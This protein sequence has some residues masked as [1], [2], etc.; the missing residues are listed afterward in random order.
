MNIKKAGVLLDKITAILESIREN[1]IPPNVVEMKRQI[2][3]RERIKAV[4]ARYEEAKAQGKKRIPH[5]RKE[6]EEIIA[7][8]ERWTKGKAD[9]EDS[10]QAPQRETECGGYKGYL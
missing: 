3:M 9:E 10:N 6:A 8:L 1:P 5:M 2:A 4:F 7:T